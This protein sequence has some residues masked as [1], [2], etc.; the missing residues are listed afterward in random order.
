M[1]KPRLIYR[2]CL[3][4]PVA[5]MHFASINGALAFG[6]YDTNVGHCPETGLTFVTQRI[7]AGMQRVTRAD[8]RAPWA[9]IVDHQVP[10]NA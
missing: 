7:G 6:L 3:R 1:S 9:L 4:G 5:V 10:A 8:T 2:G